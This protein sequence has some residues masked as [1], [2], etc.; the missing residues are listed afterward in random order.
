MKKLITICA[1]VLMV[2]AI[3]SVSAQQV[4][5]GTA[6]GGLMLYYNNIDISGDGIVS[7][8]DEQPSN[9]AYVKARFGY[10][11][12]NGSYFQ[13]DNTVDLGGGQ[14]MNSI[15]SGQ[16]V[17][18]SQFGFDLQGTAATYNNAGGVGIPSVSFADNT[19]NNASGALLTNVIPNQSQA[20]WA[21][22]NYQGGAQTG[23]LINSLFRGTSFTMAVTN[24]QVIGNTYVMTVSGDL[25]SDGIFHWY[26]IGQPDSTLASWQLSNKLSYTGTLIYNKDYR[27]LGYENGTN[28]YTNGLENGHDQMDFYAG[29]ID[30]YATVIP[31][32]ATMCLL[33]LGGLLLRRKK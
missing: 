11:N 4:K 1:V 29:N 9:Q 23:Q 32:P 21:I 28:T 13:F 24:F 5:V 33:G 14:T 12:T 10:S 26:T 27:T 6:G 31:E 16:P 2:L 18:S 7:G 8:Y 3:G 22:N 15:F 20:A 19:N 30:V 25:N 17:G